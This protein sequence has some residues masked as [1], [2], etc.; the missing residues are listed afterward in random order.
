MHI[1]ILGHMKEVHMEVL[2]MFLGVWTTGQI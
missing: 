2:G 1:N